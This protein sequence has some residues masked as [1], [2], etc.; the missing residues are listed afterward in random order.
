MND[1]SNPNQ[2]HGRFEAPR[3]EPI[4]PPDAEEENIVDYSEAVPPADSFPEESQPEEAHPHY[5]GRFAARHQQPAEEVSEIAEPEPPI[6]PEPPAEEAATPEIPFSPEP[7]V[8]EEA[9]P[10]PAEETYNED[11]I[12]AS[13]PILPPPPKG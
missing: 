10:L 7:P 13:D 8:E 6:I 1:N 11:P 5:H 4:L 2:K 9:A 3:E 12:P